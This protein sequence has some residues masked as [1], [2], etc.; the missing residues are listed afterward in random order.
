MSFSP[1]PRYIFR[2]ITDLTPSFLKLLGVKFLMLDLDNTIAELAESSPSAA[3]S[4]WVLEL[5][6]GGVDLFIVSNSRRSGRVERFAEALGIGFIKRAAK[7]STKGIFSALALSSHHAGESALVGDQVYTDVLAA[8]RAGVI[9][10]AVH[11]LKFHTPLIFLRYA[12]ELP[13]RALC[14][15]H[16]A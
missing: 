5:K 1:V 9:S 10:I 14:K 4:R 6:N 15:F 8:N 11:P 13:F 3:V 7:P 12:V 2:N 16:K